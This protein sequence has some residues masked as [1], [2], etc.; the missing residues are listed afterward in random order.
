MHLATSYRPSAELMNPDDNQI[1]E[2]NRDE[3]P[4]AK[5]IPRQLQDFRQK[6]CA[7]LPIL[8]ESLRDIAYLR[9]SAM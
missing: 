9:L 6:P 7:S 3:K 1:L 8:L 2:Q 4:F 5:N